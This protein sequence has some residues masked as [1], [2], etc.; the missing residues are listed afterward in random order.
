MNIEQI[1]LFLH[2]VIKKK[3]TSVLSVQCFKYSVARVSQ[4]FTFPKIF[5]HS[6]KES[7]SLIC[8]GVVEHFC[9]ALLELVLLLIRY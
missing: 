1:F 3:T 6:L 2:A 7:F 9:T 8:A 4:S 5:L